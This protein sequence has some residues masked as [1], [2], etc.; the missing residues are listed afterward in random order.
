[1]FWLVTTLKSNFPKKQS[2]VA[3]RA[4]VCVT[5]AVKYALRR[6]KSEMSLRDVKYALR[7]RFD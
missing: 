6:V 3:H 5:T 7:A 4:V 2:R 1:M